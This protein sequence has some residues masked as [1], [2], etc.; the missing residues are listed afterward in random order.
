MADGT[1]YAKG[2]TVSP[3][4][5]IELD[6]DNP[7]A[8]ETREEEYETTIRVPIVGGVGTADLVDG[9][10]ERFEEK[11]VTRTREVKEY[12]GPVMDVKQQL[13]DI[14]LRLQEHEPHEHIESNE[15]LR[16]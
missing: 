15:H 2:G 13:L 10:P 11:T 5:I 9:E 4:M 14:T 6:A 12:V 16:A 1:I 8:Y 7:D 3:S